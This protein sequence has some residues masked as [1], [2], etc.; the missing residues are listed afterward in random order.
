MN[1][2]QRKIT[3]LEHE[4]TLLKQE[5][6]QLKKE[7]NNQHVFQQ[8]IE[9]I[10]D[11]IFVMDRN[12]NYVDFKAGYGKVFLKENILRGGNIMEGNFVETDFPQKIIN[13]IHRAI[14]TNTIDII[15]YH[16]TFENG[17]RRF[18]ESRAIKLNQFLALR[19]VRDKT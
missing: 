12:G 15:E 16:L 17:E 9:A 3:N 19:I 6:L 2:L 5:L 14:H 8:I 13:H 11:I 1:E 7:Q 18:Y 4:N 10:P